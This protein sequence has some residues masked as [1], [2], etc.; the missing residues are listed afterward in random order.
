MENTASR[1]ISEARLRSGLSLREIGRRAGTSHATLHAYIK[2]AKSPSTATLTRII[3]AC[4]LALDCKLRP[5]VRSSHGLPR[6]DELA[7]VL[8]LA[9][10]F[11]AR[12]ARRPEYPKFPQNIE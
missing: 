10:Q 4:D 12:P 11:P 7:Q 1:L 3:T 6:G 2:G 9:E 8:R 5:R